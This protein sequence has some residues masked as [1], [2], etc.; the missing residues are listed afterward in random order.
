M[1]HLCSTL[2]GFYKIIFTSQL[3]LICKNNE[4]SLPAFIK[5]FQRIPSKD[6]GDGAK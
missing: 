5:D 2:D 3:G 6:L 4:Y 1:Q